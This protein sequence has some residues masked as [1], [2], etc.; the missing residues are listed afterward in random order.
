MGS[1]MGSALGVAVLLACA[2]GARCQEASNSS[3]WKTTDH[4]PGLCAT[5]DFCGRDMTMKGIPCPDNSP[6]RNVTDSLAKKLEEYCPSLWEQH[7]GAG[8]A[9]CTEQQ[10]DSLWEEVSQARGL[11]RGCPACLHN[12]VHLHC[13]QACS[14]DQATFTNVTRAGPNELTGVTELKE[15]DYYFSDAFKLEL[16]DSCKNVTIPGTDARA[17]QFL[18]DPSTAQDFIDFLGMPTTDGGSASYRHSFPPAK[19]TPKGMV[20]IEDWLAQCW[21]PNYE[22]ACHDCPVKP[23]CMDHSPGVCTVY[24]DCG[25]DSN[26]KGIPCPDSSPARNVSDAMAAKLANYCPALWAQYGGTGKACCTEQQLDALWADMAQAENLFAGCPAC[27][28]NFIHL[29]CV[30][31]CSPDQSTYMNVTALQTNHLTGQSEVKEAKYYFT[32]S[33]KNTLFNSCKNVTLGQT[34]LPAFMFLGNPA[35][36]Q[37]FLD[38][39]GTPSTAGGNA[40][41]HLMFPPASDAPPGMVAVDDDRPQCWTRGFECSCVDCPDAPVCAASFPSGQDG[42]GSSNGCSALGLGS[43]VVSCWDLSVIALYIIVAAVLLTTVRK[44][45]QLKHMYEP[46]LPVDTASGQ[47][48]EAGSEYGDNMFAAGQPITLPVIHKPI[49][50]W[51]RRWFRRQ[52]EFV[53]CNPLITILGGIVLVGLCATGLVWFTVETDPQMLWVS[54]SSRAWKDK[55]AYEASFGP[56]YRVENFIVSTTPHSIS[57]KMTSSGLPSIGMGR[58]V[59]LMFDIQDKIDGIQATVG[60]GEAA[61]NVTLNDVCFKPTG[62]VCGSQSILQ[63]W[64]MNRSVWEQ[65]VTPM[66]RKDGHDKMSF[67]IQEWP[68]SCYSA[69]GAPMDPKI[70]LG[71]F[72]SGTKASDLAD[73]SSAFVVTFLLNSSIEVRDAALAWEAEFI[74][75]AKSELEAM[76]RGANV[77]L[78]FY[79]ERSVQDELQR[80]SGADVRT[81]AI[82]YLVMFAYIALAL[83]SIP[84]QI[85]HASQ[86]AVATR[87]MLGAGGVVIVAGSVVGALGLCG[88]MRVQATLIIMEVI[89]FLT[90][91]VGVDNMFI[92]AYELHHQ[93]RAV[94]LFIRMG[95]AMSVSGPSVTLAAAAEVL[96]FG[97]AALVPVPA[98]RSFSICAA[99]ALL[100]DFILQVTVFAALLTLDTYR[101][102]SHRA[103]CF[104]CIKLGDP[105]AEETMY[106]VVDSGTPS[107]GSN[108][109]PP[110]MLLQT[111]VSKVHAPALLRPPVQAAVLV[112]TATMF[113]A[114]LSLT[115]RLSKGL[116][117]QVA[118]PR[119]S[120]LQQYFGDQMEFLRVGPPVLFVVR[121]MDVVPGSPDVDKICGGTGCKPNSLMAQISESKSK[122]LYHLES[123]AASWIDDFMLW[124]SPQL[125]HGC[126]LDPQTGEQCLAVE[127]EY[128]NGCEKCITGG[129]PAG[130]RPNV[131]EFQRL[132]P[133]FL[134]TLPNENCSQAGAAAYSDSIQRDPADPTGIAGLSNGTIVASSFR[135]AYTP[136]NSQAAFIDSLSDTYAFVDSV[137]ST[138]GMDIYAYSTFHIF[139]QS[140]LHIGARAAYVLLLTMLT[141]ALVCWAVLGSFGAACLVLLCVAMTLVDLMGAMRLWGVQLNGVSVVNLTMGVGIAVEF[142]VHVAHA[143]VNMPGTRAARVAGAL[144]GVGAA[145]I[146]GITLTKF[147]GVIVLA[148]SRTQI[149]EIYYFRMYLALV[150]LGAIHGLVLLPVLL[151]LFGPRPPPLADSEV[152]SNG[153]RNA[154]EQ[155][156]AAEGR[157]VP[158]PA[159]NGAQTDEM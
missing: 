75:L 59:D 112:L 141:S 52:G 81:V 123:S 50:N 122:H 63:Y 95:E 35:N 47:S 144:E 2:W 34:T 154:Y 91:A 142:C 76:A 51:L 24:G 33:F 57:D 159:M 32:D 61:H 99:I 26:D 153:N 64:Q 66:G 38:F 88:W 124:I 117:Q 80:E 145:V 31:S 157:Y 8:K 139:F 65:Q 125:K 43:S 113:F 25:K 101:A 98:V 132:L 87:F 69:F 83:S 41:Y 60:E 109:E 115:S 39:L 19:D 68:R 111:Y 107:Q 14:P 155:H 78:S 133:W 21:T 9:C 148:F 30:V 56:F 42:S 13:V 22:C 11:F 36:S 45:M 15:A 121:D 97:L 150:I 94:P 86:M 6:A 105:C 72:S 48:V 149:F 146:S 130:S 131:S 118:L 114:S 143:F 158:P 126:H 92:M 110:R 62:D 135:A 100:L 129:F 74:S 77:S 10:L 55:V 103:D 20:P 71:G 116:E 53:A 134:S 29:W 119:D 16:F 140:Y 7:A 67:C 82:S 128:A 54:K 102:E 70:V 18:G 106:A 5:Y 49:E 151:A 127:G 152:G 137:R 4:S 108:P 44:G 17:F 138:L 104:P 84:Q 120:Y 93:N 28:S 89:P 96:A 73:D 12:Y 27:M 40:P 156:V 1:G 37:A 58:Y 147:I 3:D 23:M 90:L 46:L 85:K 136:L 79:S